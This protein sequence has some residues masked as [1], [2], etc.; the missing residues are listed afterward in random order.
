[1][2]RKT[3]L[4]S[5]TVSTPGQDCTDNT[6]VLLALPYMITGG[7]D[8]VLLQIVDHLNRHGFSVSCITSLPVDTTS[9]GDNTGNYALITREIFHLPQ[10]FRHEHECRAFISDLI[11]TRNI[12]VLLIVGCELVYHMLPGLKVRFPKLKVV[13]QL[14]NEVGHIE[15]NRRYAECID[16]NIVATEVIRSLLTTKYAERDERIKVILHGVDVNNRFNPDKIKRLYCPGIDVIPSDAF[17]AGFFGRFSEEKC[18]AMFVAALDSLK[19]MD[20][21]FGVMTGGGPEYKDIKHRIEQKGLHNKIYAPG[22]VDDIRPFLARTNA[23]VIPSFIEGIPIILMEAFALGIPVVASRVG[24]MPSVIID[25]NNGFLCE[26][27]DLAG[28]VDKIRIL[29]SNPG[30]RSVMGSNAR[31]YAEQ[32][33]DVNKM[34][35]DYLRVFKNLIDSKNRENV[36]I[37]DADI[38][39][40]HS[41]LPSGVLVELKKTMRQ[42]LLVTY[43]WNESGGGTTFPKSVALELAERGYDVAVFYASLKND[44]SMSQYSIEKTEDAGVTLY[45]VFNRPALFTDADNPER[46]ICDAGVLNRFQQVLDEVS[47]DLVHFHNFHGLTFALAEET[48]RRNIP[49]CFTPHNYHLIDP[50]LYLLNG[51]LSLWDDIDLIKNSEAVRKNPDKKK[52]YEKRI[53]TT[54]KLLNEWVDLTLSV[55]S[56][57][58]NLLI[59]HGGDPEKIAL[60]HQANKSTDRLWNNA[61]LAREAVRPLHAPLRVGFVGGAIPIK[62]VHYLVAAAQAFRPDEIEVHI[63]GT[64]TGIYLEHLAALDRKGMVTFHGEYSAEDLTQIAAKLDLSV[65][66]SVIEDCAPLTLL[67]QHAMRLPIIAA[68]IGG[69]PD[70]ITEG[71]DGLLY[72]PFD[73]K[74]L[75]GVL[76]ICIDNPSLVEKMRRNLS[77]PT[78]T[79]NRYMEHLE[80]IYVS[81]LTGQK[82]SAAALSLMINRREAVAEPDKASIT[83]HGALFAQ[84]SLAHVNRELC[85]QLL[86]RGYQISFNSTQSDDFLSSVDPRFK[87]LESIRNAPMATPDIHIRHQWPPDFSPVP[88]G[89]LVLIQPWEFGSLPKSWIEPMN[90]VVDEVWVPSSYV[91]E[92]YVASGVEA[93]RVQVVPNGVD[94]GQFNPDTKPYPLATDKAFRFLFVGGTIHRKGIDLLLGAYRT[95]FSAD[96]DVCL[97]I[98]DMGGSSFYQ[99]QTAQELISRFRSDPQAPEIEYIDKD[100]ST[101]E[102]ASLYKA[103][104]CLV[105]P[106]RGEGFGLPIAEA[107]ACGLAPIVTGYGAAL[108]FCPSEIAWLLPAQ[109][110]KLPIKQVGTLETADYPWLAEPDF[111]ALVAMLRHAAKNPEEVRRRGRA[112]ADFIHENYTWE[113]AARIAVERL[114]AVARRPIRRLEGASVQCSEQ[115]PDLQSPMV[116]ATCKQAERLALAGKVNQAIELLLNEGIRADA[117]D[118]RPYVTLAEILIREGRFQDALEVLPEMPAAVDPALKQELAAICHCGLGNDAAALQAAHLATG[119]PRALTVLGTLA[120]RQGDPVEAERLFRQAIQTDPACG[121]GWLSLGMLLWGQGQQEEAWQAVKQAVTVDPL[122]QQAVQILRD[123]A[124]RLG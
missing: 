27:G 123:M 10:M 118:P 56:R 13:D 90:S 78:H 40:N 14:F 60:V 2:D 83:W 4:S 98:K 43:G 53:S 36:S 110:E 29:Y 105:H 23:V 117:A 107:M 24:G 51:D 119:R 113:H 66:P 116:L 37:S 44:P 17:V 114:Q 101:A 70:F 86:E 100:L 6:N 26:P 32:H 21:I 8:T 73:L 71:I 59:Q 89:K 95:A 11:A 94:T 80:K 115:S 7:A 28:F 62:G 79:F 5:H 93:E 25:G 111:D 52:W 63:Y 87:A 22:F 112:A 68:R 30:L 72:D 47:P 103:C 45:G 64:A 106:Y 16:F 31:K 3:I 81:M 54:R 97:V 39:L 50:D 42:I 57:Q 75:V 1:M 48:H 85:L 82:L 35:N 15:N 92:C 77:K 91:K 109:I 55:S 41:D 33:L 34:N 67:E 49:S 120:A 88:S 74:S 121:S 12:D 104:H 61:F 18:P 38:E 99:G 122:N 76:R 19:N 84:H 46:E 108:D 96:D 9:Q 102:I 65:V 58:R 20:D 124:E 69:I